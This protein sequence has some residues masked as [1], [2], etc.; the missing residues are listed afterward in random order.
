MNIQIKG[1]VLD[2]FKLEKSNWVD[3]S[4]SDDKCNGELSFGFTPEFYDDSKA[5]DI[6]FNM[7]FNHRE[8]IEFTMMYRAQFITDDVITDEFKESPFVFVNSPAIAYPFLR[9]YVSNVLLMS[10]YEPMM[11]P[12][13]NF[14]KLYKDKQAKDKMSSNTL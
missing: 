2:F 4:L 3:E 6:V 12:T 8:G 11:L 5:Y 14:Q 9:A 13:I 1:S 7:K 10:G